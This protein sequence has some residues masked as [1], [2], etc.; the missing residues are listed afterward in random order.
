MVLLPKILSSAHMQRHCVRLNHNKLSVLK[1]KVRVV[2]DISVSP[3]L[4]SNCILAKTKH[5]SVWHWNYI[6]NP[7][8]YMHAHRRTDGKCSIMYN[9]N[10]HLMTLCPGLP[11]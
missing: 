5:H 10:T 3:K 2:H 9:N 8:T 7:H 1:A 4:I 6:T 11:E